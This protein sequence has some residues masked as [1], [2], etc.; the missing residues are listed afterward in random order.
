VLGLAFAAWLFPISSVWPDAPLHVALVGDE[1][2]FAVGQR[3]FL[4]EGW[5]WPLLQA[6]KLAAPGGTNIAMT[7]SIPLAMLAAKL[8]RAWLPPGFFLTTG[9]VALVW[10]LQP[11]AAVYALRGAGE[12]RWLP[13]LAV[14]VLSVSMPTMLVRYGHM[15]L[16]THAAILTALGLYLRLVSGPCRWGWGAATLLL[17]ICLLIHPYIL[18]MVVTVLAAVPL[19]LLL[20]GDRRWRIA[21]PWFAGSTALVWV[22]A[23]L[24]GYG[25]NQPP[26]GFGIYSMNLLAPLLPGRSALFPDETIDATGGQTLEGF[27]YLGAGSLLLLLVVAVPAVKGPARLDWRRHAGLAAV[28]LGLVVFSL[29]NR[30]YAGHRLVFRLH[31]VVP[32]VVLQF[33]ATGRF[34]WP[35]AYTAMTAAVLLAA[36]AFPPRRAAT[37]L[38]VAAGLQFVE[39]GA[40]RRQIHESAL[41]GP[42]WMLDEPLLAPVFTA[43]HSLT[44]WPRFGCGADETNPL[45]MQVLL[46]A[47]QTVMHTNTM[48]SARTQIDPDCDAAAVLSQPLRQ[49]ELRVIHR[50]ALAWLVPDAARVC[51]RLGGLV[52]CSAD[53]LPLPTASPLEASPLPLGESSQPVIQAVLGAGWSLPQ[54]DG[55]WSDRN[56][57][58]LVFHRPAAGRLMLTIRGL[59]FAPEPGGSQTIKV[60]VDGT[61]MTTWQAP[62]MAAGRFQVDLPAG[63]P[64][65]TV[66]DFHITQP[67]R[68]VDRH[69]NGDARELGLLLQSLRLDPAD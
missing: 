29:S 42:S 52:L 15:A 18:A 53:P 3:Y 39:A 25:G 2:V 37:L 54:P 40:Q 62:D 41:T 36:R 14:A 6:H 23:L 55:I 32:T 59:G 13:A 4:A 44:L 5:G 31:T 50:P 66:V 20:R 58:T 46:L 1:A 43:H 7:D 47:S 30:V 33:R 65:P 11:A 60:V 17:P 27:Q 51:R 19:S 68:P 22:V 61:A 48:F 8:V 67:A 24:L 12:R 26:G 45:A 63:G 35:V 69:M 64:D 10:S 9:W 16:C 34:F 49:G 21:V 57:A 56:V 28:L 38:V